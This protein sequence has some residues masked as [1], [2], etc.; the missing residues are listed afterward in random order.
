MH[1]R[2]AL[3]ERPIKDQRPGILATQIYGLQ[4]SWF[5]VLVMR[6]IIITHLSLVL[7][8]PSGNRFR[9]ESYP[10]SFSPYDCSGAPVGADGSVIPLDCFRLLTPWYTRSVCLAVETVLVMFYVADM[11]LSAYTH[12]WTDTL[13]ILLANKQYVTVDV[14]VIRKN[15]VWNRARSF[16]VLVMLVDL[17][18]NWSGATTIRI[19]RVLRPIIFVFKSRELRRWMYLIL[20]TLPKI[21]GLALL[22]FSFIAVYAIVGVLLFSEQE[23]Y[24]GGR[25]DYANF[26]DFGKATVSLYVLMTSENFP[27]IMYPS[28]EADVSRGS[29]YFAFFFVSFLLVIMFF[30]TNLA[31]P[32]LFGSFKK[33]HV[34]EALT[35]RIVERISL[36]ASFQLLDFECKGFIELDRFKQLMRLVR[37]DLFTADGSE[38][39]V[40]MVE[41]MFE[42]L[43]MNRPGKCFPLDFFQLSEVIL[44]EFEVPDESYYSLKWFHQSTQWL[45]SMLLSKGTEALVLAL[46]FAN[47]TLLAFYAKDNPFNTRIIGASRVIVFVFAGEI[48]LKV[49][50]IGPY[51]YLSLWKN[52][53]DFTIVVGA[54]IASIVE[55]THNANNRMFVNPGAILISLRALRLIPALGIFDK[56]NVIV[57]ILP[58][59][60]F[61]MLTVMLIIYI[62]AIVGME[63]FSKQFKHN[64]NID[65]YSDLNVQFDNFVGA[66]MVLFQVLVSN[67]WDDIMY[68]AMYSTERVGGPASYFILFHFI[69]VSL[70]LQLVI[71]IY[72]EAFETFAGDHEEEKIEAHAHAQAQATQSHTP[73]ATPPTQKSVHTPTQQHHDH[74]PLGSHATNAHSASRKSLVSQGSDDKSGTPS[75]YNSSQKSLQT[76]ASP[77]P[78]GGRPRLTNWSST[79]SIGNGTIP[80]LKQGNFVVKGGGGSA[81]I[82][83]GGSSTIHSLARKHMKEFEEVELDRIK[84]LGDFDV[85]QEMEIR[86]E[87]SRRMQSQLELR[88]AALR[89]ILTQPVSLKS[90]KKIE[91]FASLKSFDTVPKT[92]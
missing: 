78:L 23:F 40:G 87:Q 56:L 77:S 10:W 2:D 22:I 14:S 4:H 83:R 37:K 91:T 68:T 76:G 28:Y 17:A 16:T 55:L 61:S 45:A 69:A 42:E 57:K 3:H 21:T 39:H 81:P 79:R 60:Y 54:T 63:F 5:V 38:R 33:S 31:V 82:R 70:L 74:K 73:A 7:F 27:Y 80:N 6:L 67:N 43:C 62:F 58:F 71:A 35:G 30:L 59:M 32:Y 12:G 36:L 19:S 51:K 65:A 9:E 44:T 84:A 75:V 85:F 92:D 41:F 11:G 48:L 20:S 13:G 46:V 15:L 26:D 25:F 49:L 24:S 47:T 89:E 1:I 66:L 50:F 72:V 90:L 52:R 8:E 18:L 86:Q 64:L 88:E 34:E 53:Y 29:H